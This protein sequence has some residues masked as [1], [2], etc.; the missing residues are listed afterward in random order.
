MIKGA[1]A[2]SDPS[3]WSPTVAINLAGAYHS[4]RAAIPCLKT[5][6]VGKIIT[7]CSGSRAQ[8]AA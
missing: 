5:R 6:G 1:V 2:E 4:A 8:S 7:I 3:E